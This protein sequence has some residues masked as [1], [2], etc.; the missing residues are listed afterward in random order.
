MAVTQKEMLKYFIPRI[1]EKGK[2]YEKKT[3]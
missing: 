3:L 2:T 1:E